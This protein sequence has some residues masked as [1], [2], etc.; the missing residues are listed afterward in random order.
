MGVGCGNISPVKR[1]IKKPVYSLHGVKAIEDISA[2]FKGGG[3]AARL[4]VG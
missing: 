3:P 4:V 2:L 1:W